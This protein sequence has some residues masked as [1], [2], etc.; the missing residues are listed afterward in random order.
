MLRR[1]E[2]DLAD[3]GTPNCPE[4]LHPMRLV[5]LAWWCKDCRITLRPDG[6]L[7]G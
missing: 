5:V 3:V 7:E 1:M 6:T 2:D 4:C